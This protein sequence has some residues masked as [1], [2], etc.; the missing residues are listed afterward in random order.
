L[1]WLTRFIQINRK[2]AAALPAITDEDI[3]SL[4]KLSEHLNRLANKIDKSNNKEPDR[5]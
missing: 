3:K 4:W 1:Y 2:I 5:Q